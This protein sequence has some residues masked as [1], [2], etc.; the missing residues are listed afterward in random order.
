MFLADTVREIAM[1]Q[2]NRDDYANQPNKTTQSST[3]TNFYFEKLVNP[4]ATIW[5]VPSD[6]TRHLILYRYRQIQD[7]GALTN[8]LELPSRWAESITWHWALRLAFEIPE[9]T[10]DRRKEVQ[11][12]AASMVIEVEAGETDSA[13]TFFAPRIGVYT[14]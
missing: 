4:Q 7:V 3:A 11:A 13:P 9:V 10:P 5:P 12:M 1:A 8:E 14:R 6:D 2:F